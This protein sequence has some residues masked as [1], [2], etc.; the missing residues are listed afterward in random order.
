MIVVFWFWF[1]TVVFL[2]S[3]CAM[4]AW[5]FWQ[6]YREEAQCGCPGCQKDAGWCMR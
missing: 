6:D 4:F 3:L 2:L 5:A 1:F